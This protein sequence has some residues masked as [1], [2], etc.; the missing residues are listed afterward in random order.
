MYFERI[1][2]ITTGEETIRNYTFEE[3]A[4]MEENQIKSEAIA[5]TEKEQL[6]IRQSALKKLLDLGLT[7]D[8]IATL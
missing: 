4:Q 1:I 6:A 8:E 5:K 7:E 3:I 2:D